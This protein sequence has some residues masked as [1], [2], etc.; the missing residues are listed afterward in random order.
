MRT[1][2]G[3]SWRSLLRGIAF[4]CA[5][6]TVLAIL[7]GADVWRFTVILMALA[8]VLSEVVEQ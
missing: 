3:F 8:V 2:G 1:Q 7:S 5:V 4:G 6:C